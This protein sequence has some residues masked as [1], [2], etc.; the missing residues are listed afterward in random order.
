MKSICHISLIIVF[1]VSLNTS[2]FSQKSVLSVYDSLGT[3][4]PF[5]YYTLAGEQFTT[6]NLSAKRKTVF[7]YF[8]NDCPY[9]QKQGTIIADHI[10]EFTSTDFI[11]ITRQDSTLAQEFATSHH[12]QNLTNVKF[13]MDKDKAYYSY[14]KAQYTPSIHIYSKHKKLIKFAEGVMKPEELRNYLN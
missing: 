7:I 6:H 11:F 8:K 13:V 9:C 10:P 14:C 2:A 3:M 5:V 4:P 12:L 1:I